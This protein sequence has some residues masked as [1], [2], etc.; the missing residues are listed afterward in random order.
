MTLPAGGGARRSASEKP[1]PI[2]NC[3]PS[4]ISQSRAPAIAR[5]F[6]RPLISTTAG[7]HGGE[8]LQWP[9]DI[10]R[11]YPELALVVDGGPGG[12]VPT[13]VVDFTSGSPELV[14]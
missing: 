3:L 13:T 14:R 8:P 9:E 7:P 1:V 12:V 11:A 2:E 5:E 4:G 10:A 6:G